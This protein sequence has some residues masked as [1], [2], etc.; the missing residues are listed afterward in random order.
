MTR[1]YAE[2]AFTDDVL[3]AQREWGTAEL[4][5][6]ALQTEIDPHDRLI[7]STKLF[8]SQCNTAFIATVS[9]NGWPY[10]Q[11]RGGDRGFIQIVDDKTLMLPDFDGNGQMITVGNLKA[12]A[13]SMLFLIDY[14]ARRRLKLWGH[15]R[16]VTPT[17][18]AALHAAIDSSIAPR[19]IVFQLDAFNFNCP[20]YI[21]QMMEADI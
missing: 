15:S 4:C 12:S 14:T 16:I 10:V 20:A 21:P 18:A 5:A 3:A 11:H 17:E 19:W 13:K 7:P 2:I 8:V 9:M 6:P 1:A